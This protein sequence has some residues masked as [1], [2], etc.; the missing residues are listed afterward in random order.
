[1]LLL[2]T[3]HSK[4]GKISRDLFLPPPNGTRLQ[5][6]VRARQLAAQ[7]WLGAPAVSVDGSAPCRCKYA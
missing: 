5:T 3:D 2:V 1:V 7:D 6:P 4:S